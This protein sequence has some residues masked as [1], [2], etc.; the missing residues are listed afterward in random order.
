MKKLKNI[1]LVLILCTLL[2]GCGK[3]KTTEEKPEVS[4]PKLTAEEKLWLDAADDKVYKQRIYLRDEYSKFHDKESDY[5]FDSD[6]KALTE[7][8]DNTFAQ[9]FIELYNKTNLKDIMTSDSYVKKYILYYYLSLATNRCEGTCAHNDRVDIYAPK[10]GATLTKAY[11]RDKSFDSDLTPVTE[12]NHSW[13]PFILEYTDKDSSDKEYF[14]INYFDKK[15]EE[16]NI[17]RVL[18][19]EKTLEEVQNYAHK[20]WVEIYRK[21]AR[22]EHEYSW[23][24]L[25]NS[26]IDEVINNN[27]EFLDF[28]AKYKKELYYP[29]YDKD[30]PRTNASSS[31]SGKS[32]PSIGMSAAEVR[33]SS[34]GSPDKVNKDTYSWGTTE[35]WVYNKKGYIYFKNGK[36]TSISER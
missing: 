20:K 19:R 35:Q 33:K 9:K 28:Y 30:H 32:S 24:E 3:N 22:Q 17:Y 18:T 23:I 31:S 27:K 29:R 1:T 34:W 36:V 6:I 21:D 12:Y 26:I 14:L 15:D 25:D 13:V 11:Y 8:K 7:M 2:T 4:E 16:E 5:S 10:E